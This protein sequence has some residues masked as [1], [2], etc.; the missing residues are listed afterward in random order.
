MQHTVNSQ[1]LL[2]S[3]HELCLQCFCVS[4]SCNVETLYYHHIIESD[5]M[6]FYKRNWF[7]VF[8][9]SQRI[10]SKHS[11]GDPGYPPRDQLHQHTPQHK[12]KCLYMDMVMVQQNMIM[13]IPKYPN[14]SI[15]YW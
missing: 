9:Y 15:H 12:Y 11:H 2:G 5:G 10:C 4:F 14:P 13:I 6:S 8:D 3:R 7:T 1:S